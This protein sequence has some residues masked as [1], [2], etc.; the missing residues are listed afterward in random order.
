MKHGYIYS[1]EAKSEIYVTKEK[2]RTTLLACR[3]GKRVGYSDEQTNLTKC[4][5]LYPFKKYRPPNYKSSN[6]IYVKKKNSSVHEYALDYNEYNAIITCFIK[7]L[8]EY[9]LHGYNYRFLSGIGEM[10]M[11][12][13]KPKF[14][15]WNIPKAI[16]KIA[17]DKNVSYAEAKM[18]I[19]DHREYLEER[20]N[21]LLK[22]YK[23]K[24]AWYSKYTKI[25]NITFWS[26]GI[27][28]THNN[29]ANTKNPKG[30]Y[31][32]MMSFYKKNI[33]VF[34]KLFTYDRD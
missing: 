15:G 16:K 33:K 31:L 12:K 24:L 1:E 23:F 17:K 2:P 21:V 19:P 7:H 13:Y 32:K 27:V 6:H 22:G 26:L 18:M 9:L 4:Y 34:S 8:Y 29:K 30:T 14:L 5:L 20:K 28:D 10:R 11:V 3:A 25:Q